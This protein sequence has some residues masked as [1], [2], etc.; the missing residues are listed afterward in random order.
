MHHDLTACKN[1]SLEVWLMRT[2]QLYYLLDLQKTASLSKTA[3][4]FFTSHQAI[5]NA[6]KALEKE[7][8]VTILNRTHKGI[9]FT[10]AGLLLCAYAEEAVQNRAQLLEKLALFAAPSA[11]PALTGELDIYIISRFSNKYFLNFYN[12][13][14]RLHPKLS[15]SL[16]NIPITTIFNLLP[17][18]KNPFVI[19]TTA[20]ELT[21][22]SENFYGQLTA[23]HLQYDIFY[24]ARLGFCVS[25]KSSYLH[26][27]QP[28]STEQELKA[29]PTVVYHYSLNETLMLNDA[30]YKNNYLLIDNF[31]VQKKMVKSGDY[32]SICTPLEYE[33]FFKT[34]DASIQ[35]IKNKQML[36][37][38]FYYLA[39]YHN[40]HAEN[41]IVQYFL[42]ALKKYYGQK[43]E[44]SLS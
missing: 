19:L 12:N 1:L 6:I 30:N 13:Y 9:S 4:N 37:S 11:E 35:F 5:N 3:E 26:T 32:I 39:L 43:D 22:N 41:P 34:K 14:A 27:V 10:E 36:S 24:A 16:K 7:F 17:N 18:Q 33:Q 21:L 15:L 44:K 2:E 25:S 29:I 38:N 40:T 20:S 23:F 28:S 42:Q 8:R 31:E